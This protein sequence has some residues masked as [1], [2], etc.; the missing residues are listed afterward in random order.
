M[1]IYIYIYMYTYIHILFFVWRPKNSPAEH[2]HRW[3]TVPLDESPP[4][5][6]GKP[7]ATGTTTQKRCHHP[8]KKNDENTVTGLCPRGVSPKKC[9][10]RGGAAAAT[11]GPAE[12]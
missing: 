7:N 6:N 11:Q 5:S 8:P 3:P 9:W 2:G 10:E 12:Q 4:E 1:Y